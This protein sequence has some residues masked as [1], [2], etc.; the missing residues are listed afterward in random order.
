MRGSADPCSSKQIGFG[1]G[2]SDGAG[3]GIGDGEATCSFIDEE[4]IA[5]N[6]GWSGGRDTFVSSRASRRSWESSQ[7]FKVAIWAKIKVCWSIMAA[8]WVMRKF[9]FSVFIIAA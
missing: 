2:G 1:L 6:A 5:G 9:S 3:L 7:P 8:I 4:S